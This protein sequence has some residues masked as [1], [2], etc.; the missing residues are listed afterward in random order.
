MI[1]RRF[2]RDDSARSS[3]SGYGLGLAIA[4]ETARSHRARIGVEYKDGMNCFYVTVKKEE[5]VRAGDIKKTVLKKGNGITPFYFSRNVLECFYILKQ[6]TQT[7]ACG[8]LRGGLGRWENNR[9][10]RRI[11][12]GPFLRNTW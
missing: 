5:G 12:P 8:S 1:F 6:Y 7:A 11:P 4:A 10:M 3:T 9:G 2:Y